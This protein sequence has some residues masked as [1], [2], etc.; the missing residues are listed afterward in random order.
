MKEEKDEKTILKDFDDKI[1]DAEENEGDIEIRDAIFAKAEYFLE[2]GDRVNARLNLKKALEKTAG[3]SKKL[4]Y[5]LLILHTFY[6]ENEIGK[7]SEYLEICKKLNEEGGDWEKKNKLDVYRGI[8]M[9]I[10]REFSE[11]YI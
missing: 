8:M 10:K 6:E 4:E 9:I 3:N 2:K 5:N 7:F 1:K 11:V